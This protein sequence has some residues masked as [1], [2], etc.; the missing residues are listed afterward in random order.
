[1]C[2]IISCWYAWSLT[3]IAATCCLS[4]LVLLLTLEAAYCIAQFAL[5]DQP[6]YMQNNLWRLF[7][8]F[9]RIFLCLPIECPNRFLHIN[10]ITSI[11]ERNHPGEHTRLKRDIDSGAGA[12]QH[13]KEP[14]N[15]R[16]LEL[17]CLGV[18]CNPKRTRGVEGNFSVIA[19]ASVHIS[20][21]ISINLTH[22]YKITTILTK[23]TKN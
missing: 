15:L 14:P 22:S 8:G 4:Y 7:Y 1:M 13:R 12:L 10:D 21:T 16:W 23:N 9:P 11:S 6:R 5:L 3:Y 19:R 18:S 17:S 20:K 2:S